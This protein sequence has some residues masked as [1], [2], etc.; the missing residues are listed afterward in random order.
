[1]NHQAALAG[2]SFHSAW[3]L[4]DDVC[5]LNHGSFG[6]TPRVVQAAR[7]EWLRRIASEPLQ[8]FVRDLE[9]ALDAAAAKLAAFIGADARN[10][11]FVENATAAM[12][13][14][15]N[16]LALQ[17]GDEV[18]LNDHEYGAVRRIWQRA[19]D[20]QSARLVTIGLPT[21]LKT[22][23][24]VIEPIFAAVTER[25]KLIVVSHVT[26]PTALVFPVAE[27]CRRA[28][29]RGVPVCIDGPH[30]IAMRPV[31]LRLLG[32]TFYCASLHKWLSAPFGSG[33]LYVDRAWQSR[34]TPTLWSW[35]RSLSGRAARWQDEW[36]W[37]GTRDPSAFLAVP[38]A[39]EFLERAGVENFRDQGHEL[40]Q[41]ARNALTG[42][43]GTAGLSPDIENWYGTMVTVP[44]PDGP[45]RRAQPNDLD[46]LQQ[47]LWERF[48]IETWMSDWRGQRHLRVSFH[49]YHDMRDVERLFEAVAALKELW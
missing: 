39:I 24:D 44:L 19:C 22:V 43:F 15:A 33:F 3:S 34:M 28:Q 10:L 8:F 11:V 32:C 14:V 26:S 21:P 20:R 16:S 47:A 25:T 17:P 29:E 45:S 1:M 31:C 30:A 35:G 23:E 40:A 5:Y 42:L 4:P 27:I 41:A 9:P 37:P 13:V 48:R 6:P 12:N 46:P 49:L 2:R 36:N 18:L 7:E 38:A